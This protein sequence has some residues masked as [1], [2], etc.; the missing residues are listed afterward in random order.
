MDILV[1]VILILFGVVLA[2]AGLRVFFIALPIMGFLAGVA[3][4]LGI[5]DH[6]FDEGFLT[7]AAGIVVGVIIGIV[8]AVL[9]YLFWY[10]AVILGMAYI[11]AVTG[12]GLMDAFDVDTDWVIL[13]AAIVGGVLLAFGAVV[14]DLPVYWVIV[15]TAFA[16]A[17][18]AIAGVMLVFDEIDRPELN[19]GT[20]WA[21]IEQSWFWVLLWIV[22]A[23][24]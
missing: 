6:A 14:L 2:V 11:G 18:W 5:M 21:A 16:G 15:S 23:A 8:F 19:Y 12:A 7:T 3:L 17:S 1:G 4:G 22:A 10:V 9:S 13:L 24:I 20:V